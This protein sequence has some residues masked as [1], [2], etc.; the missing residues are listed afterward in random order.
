[1]TPQERID[2]AVMTS[3]RQAQRKPAPPKLA[4]A[5]E[6]AVLPGGARV[7][8]MLCLSVAR[9]C[10]DDKPWLANAAASALE[11]MHCASLVHD[12]LPC[13]DD[14]DLRRG[15]PTVHKA[16]SESLAVL[17]GD[18]LI[19]SAFQTVALR[20]VDDCAR[21]ASL[22]QTLAEATGSPHGICAGQAWESEREVDLAAYHQAKT[23]ALFWAAT[24]MGA[25]AAGQDPEEWTELGSRIGEAYQVADDLRD[26]LLDEEELGKPAGQDAVHER[27][28]AVTE[29][30][31]EGAVKKLNDSLSAAITSIPACPG[32]AELCAL[33]R[34]QA[35]RLMP[36]AFQPHT[37]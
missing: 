26:A 36:M 30:G 8:P 19:V 9:A 17:V 16:F 31:V 11:L 4:A 29:Y 37:V 35:D 34:K 2:R 24:R 28:N 10:G 14:A 20:A 13:F 33:V 27:P 7:R 1:M 25:I 21:A 3:L 5:L 23:G 12:D 32:E 18:T 22:I 15:K 6:Y